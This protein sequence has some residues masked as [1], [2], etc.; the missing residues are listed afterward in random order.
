MVRMGADGADGADGCG[1]CGW[2][3]MVRMG[4]D[5]RISLEGSLVQHLLK[6]YLIK[7]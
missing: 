2:V 5:G 4:A 7:F 3:R 1:W 6:E